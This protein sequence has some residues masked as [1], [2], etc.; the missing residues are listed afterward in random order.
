MSAGF[1][2]TQPREQ[3]NRT[4]KHACTVTTI[5]KSREKRRQDS[6]N[7]IS[8]LYGECFIFSFSFSIRGRRKE[9]EVCRS[10]RVFC[11]VVSDSGRSFVQECGCESSLLSFGLFFRILPGVNVVAQFELGGTDF[12]QNF[13][14]VGHHANE[15]GISGAG[16]VHGLQLVQQERRRR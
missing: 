11:R 3:N 4:K 10:L 12:L 8:L 1:L 15:F 16:G 9:R 6:T 7:T 14:P 2:V 13:G 5:H